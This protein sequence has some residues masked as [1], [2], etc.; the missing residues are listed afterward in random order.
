MIKFDNCKNGIY[1]VVI[2]I[3]VEIFLFIQL[4]CTPTIFSNKTNLF[5]TSSTFRMVRTG[6]NTEGDFKTIPQTILHLREGTPKDYLQDLARQTRWDWGDF[7]NFLKESIG[8]MLTQTGKWDSNI[9]PK[10]IRWHMGVNFSGITN[11]LTLPAFIL[12]WWSSSIAPGLQVVINKPGLMF[13]H[14]GLTMSSLYGLFHYPK[15]KFSGIKRSLKDLGASQLLLQNI[16]ERIPKLVKYFKGGLFGEEVK[17]AAFGKATGSRTFKQTAKTLYKSALAGGAGAAAFTLFSN[18]WWP[19]LI[20]SSMF[21]ALTLGPL[22]SHRLGRMF[23]G[24]PNAINKVEKLGGYYEEV[25]NSLDVTQTPGSANSRITELVKNWNQRREVFATTY[26]LLPESETEGLSK[27]Q[28]FLN[29]SWKM[30]NKEEQQEL[31]NTFGNESKAK[32]CFFNTINKIYT[33]R[34]KETQNYKVLKDSFKRVGKQ[35]KNFKKIRSI[36][37]SNKGDNLIPHIDTMMRKKVEIQKELA[38]WPNLVY[39]EKVWNIVG[40][41]VKRSIMAINLTSREKKI[42]EKYEGKENKELPGEIPQGLPEDIKNKILS[43]K[44]ASELYA[45]FLDSMIQAKRDIVLE[46]ADKIVKRNKLGEKIPQFAEQLQERF[47]ALDWEVGEQ[48][49]EKIVK[50]MILSMSMEGVEDFEGE[51]NSTLKFLWMMDRFKQYRKEHP[52]VALHGQIQYLNEI[53]KELRE[54]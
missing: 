20:G 16:T 42:L 35:D 27:K 30:L 18:S 19:I 14:L 38:L 46:K 39:P 22:L 12:T 40:N 17:W 36:L 41:K 34:V 13:S 29:E 51:F 5:I 52:D 1:K 24:M 11:D 48:K 9:L 4:S 2:L 10:H 6:N 37:E 3:I 44:E 33:Q 43:N 8:G 54:P 47:K 45:S 26:E 21:G 15:K 49:T 31:V 7:Y 25:I 32:I 50:K 28:T 53:V 23:Q